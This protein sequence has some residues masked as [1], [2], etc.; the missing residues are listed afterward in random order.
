MSNTD[1]VSPLSTGRDRP[2]DYSLRGD[3]APVDTEQ[4]RPLLGGEARIRADRLLRAA[5]PGRLP[6]AG[7]PA[8]LRQELLGGQLQ[9]RGDRVQ[10]LE[11][12]L[13]QATLDLAEVGVG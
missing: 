3:E 13:V 5:R 6:R 4:G 1:A 2:P 12:R 11:R 8:R 9:R 7:R 10:H